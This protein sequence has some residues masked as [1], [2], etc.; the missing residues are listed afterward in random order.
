[1]RGNLR[2]IGQSEVMVMVNDSTLVGI[3]RKK[4][5]NPIGSVDRV[6]IEPDACPE[7]LLAFTHFS[8][9]CRH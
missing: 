5:K 2:C 7:I 3:D 4:P 6:L 1:M 8:R 9:Y